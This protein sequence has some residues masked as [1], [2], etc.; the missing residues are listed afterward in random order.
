MF[1][2]KTIGGQRVIFLKFND[3]YIG[4]CSTNDVVRAQC[5]HTIEFN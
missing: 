5:N 3:G 1:F 4:W 2:E